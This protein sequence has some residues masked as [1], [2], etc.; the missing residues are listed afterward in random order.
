MCCDITNEI[1]QKDYVTFGILDFNF[2]EQLF[3][4][5]LGVT[6]I[7]TIQ[8]NF[9]LFSKIFLRFLSNKVNQQQ[10]ISSLNILIQ[11]AE[12]EKN[13]SI[14]DTTTKSYQKQKQNK[15]KSEEAQNKYQSC[16]Q[17]NNLAE[18]SI[19]SLFN[20][21]F[22]QD[23]NSMSSQNYQQDNQFQQIYN[24]S[25]YSNRNKNQI[26]NQKEQLLNFCFSSNKSNEMNF[27][28][29]Y[30]LKQSINKREQIFIQGILS[31]VKQFVFNLDEKLSSFMVKYKFRHNQQ[32]Q[33][34]H[35][36][37]GYTFLIYITD[38]KL[39]LQNKVLFQKLSRLLIETQIELLVLIFSESQ[40]FEEHSAFQDIFD[41]ERQVIKLFFSEEKL[42]QYIYNNREHVKNNYQTMIVEHF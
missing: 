21:D 40:R 36:K 35:N 34:K 17:Y 11:T 26:N 2:V 25:D 23:V 9:Q 30:Q 15:L 10:K 27:D 6:S 4:Q 42:L 20:T 32:Q 29:E 33:P 3:I 39:N 37:N 24:Q 7:K 5:C 31:C 22:P 1:F 18:Q 38:Q 16:I 13:F 41:N 14:A 8:S 19:V 28:S 12:P